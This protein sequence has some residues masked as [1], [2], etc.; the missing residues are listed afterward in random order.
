MCRNTH[1]INVTFEEQNWDLAIQSQFIVSFNKTY[2]QSSSAT[3]TSYILG[4]SNSL[5]PRIGNNGRIMSDNVELVAFGHSHTVA[6]TTD[7]VDLLA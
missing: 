3:Q 2:S 1:L 4:L 6:M 5:W 7:P